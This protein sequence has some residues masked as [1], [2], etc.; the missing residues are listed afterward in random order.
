MERGLRRSRGCEMTATLIDLTE[1][2]E[3]IMQYATTS[4]HVTGRTGV[5]YSDL[6]QLIDR[7]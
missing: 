1:L 2:L 6:L 4:V 7:V 5:V 3:Y